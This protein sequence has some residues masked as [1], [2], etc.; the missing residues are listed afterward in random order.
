MRKSICVATSIF[1]VVIVFFTSCTEDK[2]S[3]RVVTNHQDPGFIEKSSLEAYFPFESTPY[4]IVKG[5]G[6][7]SSKVIVGGVAAFG[8]GA[9]GY[10]YKGD[11]LNSYV[12]IP[13]L[14]TGFLHDM[15]EFTFSCWTQLPA[16][17]SNKI[18]NLFL[19]T[20]GDSDYGS[21]SVILDSA[22][23][24]ASVFNQANDSTY[25]VTSR[26]LDWSDN[27]WLYIT[28][29]YD[30]ATSNL[31]LYI[32]GELV[33]ENV[34]YADAT[35]TIFVGPLTPATTMTK[36]CIGAWPKQIEGVGGL[37]LSY[38]AGKVDELRIWSK[39]L[40]KDNIRNLYQAEKS[41][42]VNR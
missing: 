8:N 41:L 37:Q 34:C 38:F 16:K 12:S 9:R 40:T 7:D 11:T 33:G 32:N 22:Q 29:T 36:I 42:S 3:F 19:V 1:W 18:K 15:K 28:Y 20:G 5:R 10:A 35:G 30:Q 4:V 21:F 17:K 31:A 2:E 23:L 25:A 27:Q 6:I 24:K 26:A 13:L 39:C 14:S